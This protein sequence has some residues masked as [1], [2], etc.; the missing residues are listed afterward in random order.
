MADV[1]QTVGFDLEHH[2]ID[3]QPDQ[4]GHDEVDLGHLEVGDLLEHAGYDEPET[5]AREDRERHPDG[6]EAFEAA[7]SA[8]AL[9]VGGG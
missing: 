9:G 1:A 5:D 2:R 6:E 7:E 3:H 8:G 4:H